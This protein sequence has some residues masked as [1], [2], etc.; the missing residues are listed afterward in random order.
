M[1][2]WICGVKHLLDHSH[3]QFGHP[4]RKPGS[5]LPWKG[6]PAQVC[7]HLNLSM[8]ERPWPDT[9]PRPGPALWTELTDDH[10]EGVG[11]PLGSQSPH[12]FWRGGDR[13]LAVAG[14][15]S[16]DVVGGAAL[17]PLREVYLLDLPTSAN[18]TAATRADLSVQRLDCGTA[19]G[20]LPRGHPSMNGAASDFDPISDSAEGRLEEMEGWRGSVH[21]KKG[22]V[23]GQ[24]KGMM[25]K[26]EDGRQCVYFFGGGAP[27]AD[28]HN[29]TSALCL[30]GWEGSAP[31]ARWQQVM[32]PGTVESDQMPSPVQGVKG[33]VFQDEA[34]QRR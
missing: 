2:C 5:Q 29:A 15:Y 8:A 20:R 28:V 13:L 12:L 21:W 32:S 14:G 9:M 34:G 30:E 22:M 33:T 10:A 1:L 4:S 23:E 6:N 24:W 17:H 26:M 25:E 3:P 19:A 11:V 18:G 7:R 16:P 27:H 31:A